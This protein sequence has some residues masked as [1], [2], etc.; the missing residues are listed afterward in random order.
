MRDPAAHEEELRDTMAEQVQRDQQLLDELLGERGMDEV[1]L[2][3]EEQLAR[4]LE[5]RNDE[6]WWAQMLAEAEQGGHI[7]MRELL[8][9][10]LTF[11]RRIRDI[12]D[13]KQQSLVDQLQ[14]ARSLVEGV[15]HGDGERAPAETPGR[16][17]PPR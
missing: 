16:G 7:S 9:Y 12:A 1:K 8:T 17:E 2:S 3:R 4:Y 15:L 10:A 6:A 14:S 13:V 11:E 5:V